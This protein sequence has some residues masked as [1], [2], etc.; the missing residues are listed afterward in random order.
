[1][2]AGQWVQAEMAVYGPDGQFVGRVDGVPGSRLQVAGRYMIPLSMVSHIEPGRVYLAVAA[3]Q[4]LATPYL[5][6]GE[7]WPAELWRTGDRSPGLHAGRRWRPA[8]PNRAAPLTQAPAGTAPPWWRRLK[9]GVARLVHRRRLTTP[10]AR[11]K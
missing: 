3:R 11:G 8:R 7:M 2:G 6:P 4:Y 5:A 9:E 10:G 1:M